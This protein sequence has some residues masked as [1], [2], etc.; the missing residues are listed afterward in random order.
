[1]TE[2]ATAGLDLRDFVDGQAPFFAGTA[3]VIMQLG[4][5]AVGYGVYESKVDDGNVMLVPLKRARTTVTYLSVALLGTPAERAA[6]RRAVNRQ[7]TQVHS[8]E[9]SPVA[10][11]A[12]D[13]ELQ[14]WVA[15]CLAYG[16]RDFH[17]RFHGRPD[18]P[19]AEWLHR[20]MSRLATTLQVPEDRWPASLEEFDAYW[21]AGL[22]KVSYDDT[23]RGYLNDLLD[24]RQLPEVERRPVAAFHRWV[25]T[26]FLP[27][28]FRERMG[29]EWSVGDQVRFETR[30][31]KVGHLNRRMPR[32]LRMFPFNFFLSDFRLRNRLDLR[33]V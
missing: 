5:P 32:S 6:Y 11:D 27:P 29:L 30:M 3:N 4:W 22:E 28:E 16:A 21:A 7:H 2:T 8:D 18:R 17:E 19:T 14:L 23:L 9:H 15:A 10:Y 26:G 31:A 20:Q 13:P 1:V 12:F 33:L 24:L 25:N